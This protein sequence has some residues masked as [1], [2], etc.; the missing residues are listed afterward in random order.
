MR[1]CTEGF[2]KRYEFSFC[3]KQGDSCKKFLCVSQEA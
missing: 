3:V 2:N 1:G